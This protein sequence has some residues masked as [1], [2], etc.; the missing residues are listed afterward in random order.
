MATRLAL[1]I[2]EHYENLT[3]SEQKLASLLLDRS[4][5]FLTFSATELARLAGISKATAARLFQSLGYRDFNDVRLQAREERNRTAPVQQVATSLH[6]RDAVASVSTHLQR[7]VA[8]LVRTF[9]TLRSD[10]LADV[11]ER[12]A[13]ARRLWLVGLGPDA[14]LARY[15]RALLAP[16]R[17]SVMLLGDD[18]ESWPED[19][20]SAAGD[21]LLLMVAVQPWPKALP[22]LLQ[23]AGTTRM[24]VI[25][26]TG[27]RS[28]AK[29]LR[30]GGLALVCHGSNA[31]TQWSSTAAA[32]MIAL[33]AT[34]VADRLGS[35]A[36]RR[37]D[38][39]RTL[40]EE[41]DID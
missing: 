33:V 34:A 27:P 36:D 30:H 14:G 26:I 31:G 5:E 10:A 17:P 32:S 21:D 19:L 24:G 29:V 8:D 16:I 18:P 11:A 20:A 25:A 35:T 38:L 40:R 28:Q 22:R 41:F 37:V 13:A 23:F 3:P 12:C 4:D 39:I 15:T 6:R 7:E 1:R 2:Q 9:E